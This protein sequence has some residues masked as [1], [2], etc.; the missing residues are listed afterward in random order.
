M[1]AVWSGDGEKRWRE[2]SSEDSEAEKQRIE[3]RRRHPVM[4]VQYAAYVPNNQA[5]MVTHTRT[6]KY[7]CTS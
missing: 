5:H 4:R 3:W 6:V 1:E 2:A 7:R